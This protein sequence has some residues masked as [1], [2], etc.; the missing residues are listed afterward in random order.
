ML[1]QLKTG[2]YLPVLR[3]PPHP[4]ALA[5]LAA[6]FILPGL[7]GHDPW[8]THD[9]VGLGIVH[10]MATSG[11][12]LVP[13]V[14]GA[15]WLY[16][17]PLYHWIA[18]LFGKLLG[19]LMEFHAGARLASGALLALALAFMYRAGRDWTADETLRP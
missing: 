19:S 5:L 7:A 15:P 13:A 3:L 17:P 9:A 12:L 11:E 18:A 8:K 10:T 4:A 14:A 16:D 1:P 2:K 6:A